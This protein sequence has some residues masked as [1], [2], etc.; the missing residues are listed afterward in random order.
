MRLISCGLFC[1]ILLKMLFLY[2]FKIKNMSTDK[3]TLIIKEYLERDNK[4]PSLTLAKLIFKDHPD[5]F[6]DIEIVRKR[7]LYH[8]GQC[9]TSNRARLTDLRFIKDSS[10]DSRLLSIPE[11]D[12]TV[13]NPYKLPSIYT[14]GLIM[15]DMHF[16]YHDKRAIEACIN[17]TLGKYKP[18]FIL[19]NGDAVDCYTLS[20]FNRNMYNRSFSDEL[21]QL[22]EFFNIL[23]ATF[24]GAHIIWKLGNHEE[25]WE[26]YLWNHPELYRMQE[27]TFENILKAR[28]IENLTVIPSRR[29]IYTGRLIWYHGHELPSGI[30]TPVNPARGL[31]LRTLTSGAVS[32]YHK[33]SAH[34]DI[35]AKEKLMSWWSIG[36]LCDLHPYYA[37]VNKWNHG[38]A[39]MN[40]DDQEFEMNN[41][42]IHKG[43]IY[44]D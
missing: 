36:C 26:Y 41:M 39:I 40:V 16:P 33:S 11:S 14:Q 7:I 4:I 5:M 32:H 38:F 25:R 42:K 9:G 30:A 22:V 27:L 12:A 18:N 24:P 19:I 34:S 13:W 43:T 21:W 37:S 31:A 1:F 10:F 3:G 15:S 2:K 28:G 20:K 8:R 17:Y 44:R 6:R 35:D 23:Q 29:I